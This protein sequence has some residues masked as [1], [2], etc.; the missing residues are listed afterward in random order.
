MCYSG[1]W[2]PYTRMAA[3]CKGMSEKFTT[4]LHRVREKANGVL[5]YSA[6]NVNDCGVIAKFDNVYGCWH[7]PPD[8]NTLDCKKGSQ[9]ATLEDAVGEFGNLTSATDS[10]IDMDGLEG[11]TGIAF[12]KKQLRAER[13]RVQA[14][15]GG[16]APIRSRQT[17]TIASVLSEK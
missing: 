8:G 7:P 4:G 1:Y 15:T 9:L 3:D 10:E 5:P 6:I 16:G 14:P 17:I 12:E 13:S 11:F 2:I